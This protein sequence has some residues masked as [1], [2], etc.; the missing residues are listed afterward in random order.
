M[1]SS[2]NPEW[3][4]LSK[5]SVLHFTA[6]TI[7]FAITNAFALIPLFYGALQADSLLWVIFG[8]V[9]LFSIILANAFLQYFYFTYHLEVDRVQIKQGI[10]NKRQTDLQFTRVQNVNIIEPFYFRPLGLVTVKVDGAG[11]AGEEVY[12]SALSRIEGNDLRDKILKQ[13]SAEKAAT[14]NAEDDLNIDQDNPPDLLITRKLTDLVI[15]GLTNNRSWIVV[16]AIAGLLGQNQ[17]FL[18]SVVLSLGLTLPEIDPQTPILILGLLALGFIGV[19]MF[20]MACLSVLWAIFT[21]FNFELRR[22]ADGFVSRRGLLTRQETNLRIRR[23]QAISLEQNWLARILRRF[24]LHY[25]QISHKPGQGSGVANKLTVPSIFM[26]EARQLS[27]EALVELDLE[28]LVFSGISQGFLYRRLFWGS[29]FFLG[30]TVT[31]ANMLAQPLSVLLPL[32]ALS[33]ALYTGYWY[34]T[35]GKWGI[36]VDGDFVVVRS[37]TI[38][39]DYTLIPAFKLQHIQRTQSIVMRLRNTSNLRFGLASSTT[40]IPHLANS[41]AVNIMNYCLFQVEARP[42][43]WM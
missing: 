18:Q 3:A 25:E 10:F 23:I 9:I 34:L 39:I 20:T 31:V 43:S 41:L 17:D 2:P 27:A 19:A 5:W 30:A 16:A 29:L 37:G 35:W 4:H 32:T 40:T 8:A 14:E 7:Q 21:Y 13:L 33:Y 1:D 36:A 15:H 22:A 12:L 26:H 28:N 42:R 11:S 24:N 6:R 38:G